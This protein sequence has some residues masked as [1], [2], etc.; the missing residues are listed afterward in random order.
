MFNTVLTR[1]DMVDRSREIKEEKSEIPKVLTS[2]VIEEDT[3]DELA[4]LTQDSMNLNDD[5][6][7]H[8]NDHQTHWSEI[9]SDFFAIIDATD[10]D[11][12]DDDME[13]TRSVK[14]IKKRKHSESSESDN[15][16]HAVKS[17][18]VKAETRDHSF[19][20]DDEEDRLL[21]EFCLT[22]GY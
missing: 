7:S 9:E 2:P 16:L 8:E 15:S 21:L 1:N 5:E 13:A 18:R 3:Q 11:D 17:K 14:T 10:D 6:R 12:D 4:R 19:S 20:A 22:H